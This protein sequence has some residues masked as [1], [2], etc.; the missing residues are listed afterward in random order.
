MK[1]E[2]LY[3]T[4]NGAGICSMTIGIVLMVTSMIS[5]ILLVVSGAKLLLRKNDLLI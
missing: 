4:L 2:K 5:G 1:E 3:K